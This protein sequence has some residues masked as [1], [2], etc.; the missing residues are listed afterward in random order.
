MRLSD[1]PRPRR[2]CTRR[3]FV[4]QCALLAAATVAAPQAAAL[5]AEP[6]TIFFAAGLLT[7]GSPDADLVRGF[8]LGMEEASRAAQLFRAT[9]RAERA[10]SLRILARA[11]CSV[12]VGTVRSAASA[13]AAQQEASDRGLLYIN[14]AAPA[15]SLR[16]RECGE[17]AFH[18]I[19]SDA[20]RRVSAAGAPA[21]H[22][23][24]WDSRLTRFGAEQLND[25]YRH[26]FSREMNEQ[27]WLGWMAV[28]LAWEAAVRAPSANAGHIAEVLVQ[29]GFDGHKGRALR[30]G[31]GDRQLYQPL[32]LLP[33]LREVRPP[34][35]A[36]AVHGRGSCGR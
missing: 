2:A 25:R 12:A 31:A 30:F 6:R 14:A 36:P 7:T 5:A 21:A 20:L 1:R 28:K 33:D 10:S 11:G 23:V 27:A 19:P 16:S 32:Y 24:A 9:I 15:D 26:R 4:R 22:A 35:Q 17:L 34:A 29:R 3:D 18:V 8:Y 13:A